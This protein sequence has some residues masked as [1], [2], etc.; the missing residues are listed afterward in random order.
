[1]CEMEEIAP[2]Q[3]TDEI[4][5]G[6]VSEPAGAGLTCLAWRA[7]APPRRHDE[8][9]IVRIGLWLFVAPLGRPCTPAKFFKS[10]YRVRPGPY[11]VA[12]AAHAVDRE[13]FLPDADQG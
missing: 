4:R 6:R 13:E 12:A 11:R 2:S 9:D 7:R 5:S 3:R 1:V 8:T 10:D